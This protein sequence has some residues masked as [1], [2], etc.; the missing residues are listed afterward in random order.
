M[1][2]YDN[3]IKPTYLYIKQHSVT[4]LKYFGKTVKPNPTKYLGS[5]TYW[6]QHIKKHGKEYVETTWVSEPYIDKELLTT[7]ALKFS[8]EN[9]IV[10]SNQWANLMLENGLDGGNCNMSEESRAKLSEANRNRSAETRAKLSEAM[11]NRKVSDETRAKLSAVARN[12]APMSEA[13][14]AKISAANLNHPVSDETRAKISASSK[15]RKPISEETRAKMSEAR[16]NRKTSDETRAKMSVA[17]R[18][19]KFSD[20]TRAKMC[21]AQ[22][23]IPKVTCPHCNKQG[24]VQSMYRW[25]FDNC[26]FK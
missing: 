4:G 17:M 10:N 12:R 6:K 24:G 21:I 3:T 11:R 18:N 2:I 25:H 13:V 9:D 22:Q 7:A 1:S 8:I 23:S 14:R 15:H 26:K 19:R 16:R 5:G 20:E